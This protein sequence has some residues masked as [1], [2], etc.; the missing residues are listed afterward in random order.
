[1]NNDDLNATRPLEQLHAKKSPPNR[2]DITEPWQWHNQRNESR[3]NTCRPTQQQRSELNHADATTNPPHH[4]KTPQTIQANQIA[5][6]TQKNTTCVL[7][8]KQITHKKKTTVIKTGQTKLNGQTSPGIVAEFSR[9]RV[10][11]SK[12]NRLTQQTHNFHNVDGL[13]GFQ[14]MCFCCCFNCLTTCASKHESL[15]EH[16]YP[17]QSITRAPTIAILMHDDHKMF[18]CA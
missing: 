8:Q 9:K 7:R 18:E 11:K 2:I 13:G 4:A 6:E 3:S 15:A 12:A 17:L 10:R 1:M 16:N 5:T 14:M